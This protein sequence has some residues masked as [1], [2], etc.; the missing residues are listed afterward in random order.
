LPQAVRPPAIENRCDFPVSYQDE[1]KALEIGFASGR[2]FI[3]SPGLHA[4]VTNLDTGASIDL[5]VNGSVRI[6]FEPADSPGHYLMVMAFRGPS[7][8][9]SPGQMT[10]YTGRNTF[11]IEYDENDVEVNVE[12][13]FTGPTLDVCA[14]LAP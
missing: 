3:A 1:G 8:D 5:N 9:L 7:M 14:A 2:Y 10:W 4:T 6:T 12:K 13:Y 11:V